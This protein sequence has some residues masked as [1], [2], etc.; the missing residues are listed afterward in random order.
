MELVHQHPSISTP[1]AGS[2]E[3]RSQGNVV[4]L[5]PLRLHYKVPWPLSMIVDDAVLFKYNQV[6]IFLLQA[7][8]RPL[9]SCLGPINHAA[10]CQTG[11]LGLPWACVCETPAQ[12]YVML[13]PLLPKQVCQGVAAESHHLMLSRTCMLSHLNR[14]QY[15]VAVT[16]SRW[17]KVLHFEA[18]QVNAALQ[19]KS[20]LPVG[21]V[22]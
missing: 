11:S 1:T 14:V 5:L 2:G 21:F 15:P 18:C 7:C 17:Y 22:P 19:G 8:F 20:F 3:A 9:S 10:V 6:L 4:E 16:Q 13:V 12:C